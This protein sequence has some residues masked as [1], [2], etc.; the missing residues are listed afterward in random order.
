MLMPQNKNSGT[1]TERI[2]KTS[3]ICGGKPRI[4]GTRI[5][6]WGLEVGR[7]VGRS[8]ANLLEAYPALTVEDLQAAWNYVAQNPD[9]IEE[10]I[11]QNNGVA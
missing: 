3:G 2:V 6:V 8:D 4:C 1:T 10:Q 7:R 5:P 9:E 11:R